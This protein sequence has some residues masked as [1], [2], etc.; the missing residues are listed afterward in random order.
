[1]KTIGI[2][3]FGSFGKFLAEKLSSHARVKVYSQHGKHSSW[4]ASLE[5][6]AQ[7]DYVI[8][9][10]PL[11][12]YHDVLTALQ[13]HLRPESVIVDVCSV[14]LKP[15]EMIKQLLPLQ[16]LVATHPMFGPESASVSFAGHTFVMCPESSSREPYEI[17]K[18]FANSLGLGV[19]E[20]TADEHDREIAVVQGLTFFVARA[21]NVFGVQD[22]KLFTPSFERLLKLSELEEHHSLELFRTIQLGNPQTQT[23]R[24]RFI[25]AIEKVNEDLR[26]TGQ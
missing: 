6:V 19:V 11:D 10:I 26:P 13:P 21:L 24:Q 3:G 25:A 12:V 9:A 5:E 20:M 16:P 1:M 2:I 18:Q 15:M 17:V 7:C 22:Q 14:K 4:E 23:V 8:P